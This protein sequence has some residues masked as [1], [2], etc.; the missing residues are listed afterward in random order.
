MK[1]ACQRCAAE[2]DFP[3]CEIRA[4]PVERGD[5]Q[6]YQI[7]DQRTGEIRNLIFQCNR[8][9]A[10]RATIIGVGISQWA[11][12]RLT[13]IK[14][15]DD[16]TPNG[17]INMRIML[18]PVNILEASDLDEDAKLAFFRLLLLCGKKVAAVYKHLK[19]YAEIEDH[20]LAEVQ[21]TA[22]Q[23]A[24][25]G[26]PHSYLEHAQ[27]LLVEFDEF[28]VQLKSALDYM[29][30]IPRIILGKDRWTVQTFGERGEKVIRALENNVPT[31]KKRIGRG[32]ARL[33]IEKHRPWLNAVIDARDR[34]NHMIGEP[35]APE[36]FMIYAA[37]R[38]GSSILEIRRP[39]WSAEQSVREFMAVI[40]E[41]FVRLVEDFVISFLLFRFKPGLVLYRGSVERGSANSPWAVTTIEERNR[42]VARPGWKELDF[43]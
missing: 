15:F 26:D 34:L 2:V 16:P 29:V 19:A 6:A 3:S 24:H 30:K 25:H 38:E 43:S 12:Q 5:A 1:L 22:G 4:V 40:W 8:C 7:R 31:E 28:L 27:D 14:V 21:R 17:Q 18:A 41:N 9:G 10:I 36:A 39:I 35:V 13:S 23:Q 42:V 33:I 32:I 37:Q 20:L 11:N